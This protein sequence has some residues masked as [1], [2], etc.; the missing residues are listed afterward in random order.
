MSWQRS[1][2]FKVA[3]AAAL[4]LLAPS[5]SSSASVFA[6]KLSAI[7]VNASARRCGKVSG[8]SFANSCSPN[9]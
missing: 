3:N 9:N 6:R 1:A 2:P 7:A 8:S 4:P 5:L